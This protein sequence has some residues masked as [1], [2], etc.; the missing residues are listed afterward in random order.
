VT[1]STN[2]RFTGPQLQA[3]NPAEEAGIFARTGFP[4]SVQV[5]VCDEHRQP[6][7]GPSE[8]DI[9]HAFQ[10][11]E[12]GNPGTAAVVPG[13][14]YQKDHQVAGGLHTWYD[15]SRAAGLQR[16]FPQSARITAQKTFANGR[17][18]GRVFHTMLPD[19]IRTPLVVTDRALFLAARARM[20]ELAAE[21]A[22]EKRWDLGVRVAR[23]AAR[24]QA[25]G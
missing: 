3:V 4:Y 25:S 8:D 19:A 17:G 12:L 1:L 24:A 7:F 2:A 13:L 21:V 23:H 15:G 22:A 5:E 16:L 11:G 6:W 14:R 18:G 9:V 20:D 10:Y